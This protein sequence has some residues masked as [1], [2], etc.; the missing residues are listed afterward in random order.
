VPPLP[1]RA[2]DLLYKYLEAIRA[3]G[4]AF[5]VGLAGGMHIEFAWHDSFHS[6][7]ICRQKCLALE[8]TSV[9]FN[10]G[11][12]LT[13]L[14]SDQG[15]NDEEGLKISFNYFKQASAIFTCLQGSLSAQLLKPISPDLTVEGLSLCHCTCHAQ[16]Q[17]C[18]YERAVMINTTPKLLFKLAA[19]CAFLYKKMASLTKSPVITK[20]LHG[21][22]PSFASL[23]MHYYEAEANF[24]MAQA[25][26]AVP[27]E[28]AEEDPMAQVTVVAEANLHIGE[29]I[30]RLQKSQA[31]L[32]DCERAM[33]A[34]QR[35]V[36]DPDLV[37][38]TAKLT[39]GLTRQLRIMSSENDLCYFQAIPTPDKL[40]ALEMKMVVK[41]P[42]VEEVLQPF[43]QSAT[44]YNAAL[45]GL[46]ETAKSVGSQ[47]QYDPPP[48]P[49]PAPAPA[50]APPAVPAFAPMPEPQPAPY[51]GGT[52][53]SMYPVAASATAP[54]P[55]M[56][57]VGAPPP[58]SAEA[59]QLVEMGF[60][61]AAA[62]QALAANNGD[63]AAAVHAL[64]RG[65]R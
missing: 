15:R 32:A 29:A 61:P 33:K 56:P 36:K 13:A 34:F 25:L 19:G 44:G 62:Q 49:A 41:E 45:L 43:Q 52:G 39:S 22:W 37:S 8:E 55:M 17:E 21:T 5:E 12:M 26:H 65:A 42:P 46:L 30:A 54:P 3:V 9:L 40:V 20:K 24:R 6:S 50:A 60:D 7:D 11:S 31:H 35:H 16:A 53:A 57:A 58:M 10:I 14:A 2:C 23:Q 47:P 48:A 1:R 64:T 4:E 28:H 18:F 27:D 38:K 59:R 63:L 51:P